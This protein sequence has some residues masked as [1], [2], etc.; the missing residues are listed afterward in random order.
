M[1]ASTFILGFVA[2]ASFV[3]ASP[4]GRWTVHDSRIAAPESF[5]QSGAAPSDKV[6]KL[7]LNLAGNNI[8][9]LEEHL[10]TVSDP[11]SATFRQWLTKEQVEAYTTP[12]GETSAAVSAWLASHGISAENITPAGDWISVSVPVSKANELLNTQYSV[13]THKA[14]GKQAIRTLEYSLPQSVAQH[15]KAIHPTTS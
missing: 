9:G 4:A 10:N 8:D 14:S 15:I 6:I 3:L 12:S 5:I 7:R 2:S 11:N 1:V 13:Y